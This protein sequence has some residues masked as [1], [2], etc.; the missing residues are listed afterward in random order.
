MG[1]RTAIS[2]CDATFNPWWGCTKVSP[3]CDLC[4]AER[5]SKRYGHEVW[6]QDAERRMLSDHNW[7]EP[8]RWNRKADKQARPWR[9]FCGSMCDILEDRRDL[10]ESRERLW[11]LIDE[12]RWI[13]WLLVSK[14]ATNFI[15]MV[16]ERHLV[17]DRVWPITTVE[18]P[19]Y[20]W[21]AFE[22]L[23][24]K[25]PIIGVSYEPALERTSF[26]D[27]LEENPQQKKW[28]IFGGES[29]PKARPCNPDWGLQVLHDCRRFNGFPFVK[30]LGSNPLGIYLKDNK[31][32]D[33]AEWPKSL[34]V[35]EFP[36]SRYAIF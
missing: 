19:E 21:R 8:L 22:L 20:L 2:W 27:W 11:R 23:K 35:Q 33:P 1:E 6:G 28:V 15:R 18:S 14:R 25:S 32:A 7:N 13:I 29:G 31:G 10:D 12:T 5:D 17:S 3:G 30:Q 36:I 26:G 16:P 24:L 9:V 4:Y 34:Q